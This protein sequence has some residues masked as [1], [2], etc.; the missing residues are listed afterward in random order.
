MSS[1]VIA[2]ALAS[3]IVASVTGGFALGVFVGR[4]IKPIDQGAHQ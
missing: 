3:L 2:L 1:I 4:R